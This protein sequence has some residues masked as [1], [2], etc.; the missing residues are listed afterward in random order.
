[1]SLRLQTA[2]AS[3]FAL[4][5]LGAPAAPAADSVSP[6]YVV[7]KLQVEVNRPAEQVW[8]RV[9]DYCAISE[10]LK[11]TCRYSSG[12]GDVGT[13]RV[14]N[15]TIIEPMVAKTAWSYTYTQTAGSVAANL[16]HG[17]VAVEPEG[18]GKSILKYTFFYNQAGLETDAKRSAERTRITTRFQGALDAMKAAAE[19]QP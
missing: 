7:I 9:S 4:S 5:F 10:W 16:Y 3:I 14:I 8:K 2:V 18:S 17:T 11:V 13:V 12:S 6:D 15:D 19:A 1:M